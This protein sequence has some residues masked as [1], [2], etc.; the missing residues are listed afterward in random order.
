MS[1]RYYSNIYWHFTGSPKGVD[2]S[3]ARC[4]KDITDQGA[5]LDDSVAAETL[6]LILASKSLWATCTEKIAEGV[7]TEKFCCVTDIPLKDLPSHSPYYGK[8]AIGFKAEAI[9]KHFIP[10]LYLPAQNLPAIEKLIPNRK[11]SK[12]ISDLLSSSGSFAEQQAMKLMP[13]AYQHTESVKELDK[14]EIG[15]FYSNF[16]KITNFDSDPQNTYYREREWRG[17]GNFNFDY[18]DI[19]AVVA[20]SSVLPAIKEK[21]EELGIKNIN[22]VSWEFVEE[23]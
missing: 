7:E 19:E 9:H 12:M 10:V 16:V 4:P 11:I 22:V 1:Q 3:I 5:I 6:S 13:L 20:P 14:N 17:I 18:G 2:W 23:A 15:G 8:V 21:L